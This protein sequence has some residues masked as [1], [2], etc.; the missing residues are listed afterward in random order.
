MDHRER[1]FVPQGVLASALEEPSERQALAEF[2]VE[3]LLPY[4]PTRDKISELILEELKK[5]KLVGGS[6]S[7]QELSARN[8]VSLDDIEDFL[9]KNFG[10][11]WTKFEKRS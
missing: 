7:F 6:V 9:R 4:Q 3:T 5:Q 2:Y 11:K 8:K 1:R 10:E